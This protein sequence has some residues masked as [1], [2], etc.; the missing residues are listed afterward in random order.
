MPN[1]PISEEEIR[2][3]IKIC[4]RIASKEIN[5]SKYSVIVR[6]LGEEIKNNLYGYE[7]IAGVYSDKE[8]ALEKARYIIKETGLPI[9]KV[10]SNGHIHPISSDVDESTSELVATTK[11]DYEYLASKMEFTKQMEKYNRDK[12]IEEEIKQEMLNELNDQ[13][14]DY[15]IR[16]LYLLAKAD[17]KLHCSKDVEE[18]CNIEIEKILQNIRNTHGDFK[19]DWVDVARAQLEKRDELPIFERIKLVFDDYSDKI[20]NKLLVE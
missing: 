15:Y 2:K 18:K 10:V 8:T 14:V 20:E 11:Q 3:S 9:A 12:E 4:M 1:V 19:D 13:T 16:Q 5:E 6:F 17:T 7:M